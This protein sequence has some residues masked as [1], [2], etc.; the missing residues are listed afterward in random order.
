M[1]REDLHF[2]LR[3]P[4]T[5]K[6]GIERAAAKNKRS[7]TAEII[8]RLETSFAFD[9]PME[10]RMWLDG[11]GEPYDRSAGEELLYRL[12]LTRRFDLD[13]GELERLR[14]DAGPLADYIDQQIGSLRL[15][16]DDLRVEL[17]N[18]FRGS[19]AKDQQTK[20][21]SAAQA[22]VD[23]SDNAVRRAMRNAEVVGDKQEPDEK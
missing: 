14:T 2:R 6:V 9:L 10:T 16:I 19:N 18:A 8:D 12:E 23:Q 22:V 11:E 13:V 15:E 20:P 7:M 4:E 21:A 5:L 1:A 3:I 17:L